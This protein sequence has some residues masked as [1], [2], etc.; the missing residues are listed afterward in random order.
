MSCVGVTIHFIAC[1]TVDIVFIADHR[2]TESKSVAIHC[3]RYCSI[4]PFP[5]YIRWRVGRDIITNQCFTRIENIIVDY[6]FTIT[7]FNNCCFIFSGNWTSNINLK[8][9]VYL[10]SNLGLYGHTK[11]SIC[12]KVRWLIIRPLYDRQ[13]VYRYML[14]EYTS[15]LSW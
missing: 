15:W 11:Y 4:I 6:F 10:E 13:T 9:T 7:A 1:F 14:H 5:S 12:G 2:F 8:L 3:S